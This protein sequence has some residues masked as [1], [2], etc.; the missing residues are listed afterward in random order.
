MEPWK[1]GVLALAGALLVS[2]LA[3]AA[4]PA[5]LPEHANPR[6]AAAQDEVARGQ[7]GRATAADKAPDAKPVEAH[8]AEAGAPAER[9]HGLLVAIEH[10]PDHVKAHLQSLWDAMQAGLSGLG[11]ALAKP[12]KPQA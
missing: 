8:P 4:R 11:D 2:G 10:V 9:G 1:L 5:A 6:A 3:V 7:D 12:A